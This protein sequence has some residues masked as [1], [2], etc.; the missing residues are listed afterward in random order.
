MPVEIVRRLVAHITRETG[1]ARIRTLGLLE[2]ALVT[3][4]FKFN[5]RPSHDPR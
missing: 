4:P 5:R 2:T 3:L 1:K